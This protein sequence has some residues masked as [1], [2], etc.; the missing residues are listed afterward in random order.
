MDDK[1]NQWLY[2]LGPEDLRGREGS[3]S[4]DHDVAFM[5]SELLAAASF[6]V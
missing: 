6:A 4:V 5:A 2:P 1:G 3:P